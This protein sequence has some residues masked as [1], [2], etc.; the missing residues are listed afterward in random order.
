MPLA[1]PMNGPVTCTGTAESEERE[2]PNVKSSDQNRQPL[3]LLPESRFEWSPTRTRRSASCESVSDAALNVGEVEPDFDAAE[4]GAFG[5]DG[6]GDTGAEMAR[7]TDIAGK[8][9]WTSRTCAISSM[10]AL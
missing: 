6:C 4:V 5:A 8:F 7:R 3:D 2:E 9:G 10:E 1:H